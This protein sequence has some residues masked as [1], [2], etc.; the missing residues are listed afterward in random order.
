M[1]SLNEA[2][3]PEDALTKYIKSL[4]NVHIFDPAIPCSEIYSKELIRGGDKEI[5]RKAIHQCY[6]KQGKSE[7]VNAQEFF[8][9][10]GKCSYVSHTC[11]NS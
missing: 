11:L 10:I 6:L 4:K 3:F 5:Y 1:E 9:N 7:R 8:N 2:I